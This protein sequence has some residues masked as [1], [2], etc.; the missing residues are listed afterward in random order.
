M[1]FLSLTVLFCF[2]FFFLGTLKKVRLKMNCF[3]AASTPGHSTLVSKSYHFLM[4]KYSVV[5]IC[6][7][8]RTFPNVSRFFF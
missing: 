4:G 7:S 8:Q 2:F 3:S 1:L 6:F 5:L